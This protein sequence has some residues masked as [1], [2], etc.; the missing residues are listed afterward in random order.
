MPSSRG[1]SPRWC[2][3]GHW[4]LPG[5]ERPAFRGTR[6]LVEAVDMRRAQDV[7]GAGSSRYIQPMDVRH[8][9]RSLHPL[10][11]PA[12]EEILLVDVGL[13][14]DAVAGVPDFGCS[15]RAPQMPELC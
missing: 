8:P 3:R 10:S 12:G 2:W 4:T 14:E 5:V 7:R 11:Q 9:V 1:Q 15:T 6:G 13:A